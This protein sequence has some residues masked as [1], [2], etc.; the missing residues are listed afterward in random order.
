MKQPPEHRYHGL[1]AMVIS[2]HHCHCTMASADLMFD[3]NH[4]NS[5]L[6][7]TTRTVHVVTMQAEFCELCKAYSIAYFN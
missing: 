5:I 7:L 1:I 2:T 6:T 4:V 3:N